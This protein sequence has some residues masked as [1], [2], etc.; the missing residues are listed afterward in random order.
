MSARPRGWHRA[1]VVPAGETQ[2]REEGRQNSEGLRSGK[3]GTRGTKPW[4][5]ALGAGIM[6][7]PPGPRQ[8]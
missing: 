2:V 3:W 8:L 6:G 5:I 7:L 1:W 4:K